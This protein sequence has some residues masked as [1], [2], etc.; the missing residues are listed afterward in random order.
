M[1]VEEAG[2]VDNF[3]RE[4]CCFIKMIA[5]NEDPETDGD[6]ISAKAEELKSMLS[7]IM[8]ESGFLINGSGAAVLEFFYDSYFIG[9]TNP[10]QKRIL[11]STISSRKAEGQTQTLIQKPSYTVEQADSF[12]IFLMDLITRWPNYIDFIKNRYQE[13]SYSS[14]VSLCCG[15]QLV[16]EKILKF[17][18]VTQIYNTCFGEIGDDFTYNINLSDNFSNITVRP[19]FHGYF[20]MLMI[21]LK[22]DFFTSKDNLQPLGGTSLDLIKTMI[23]ALLINYADKQQQRPENTLKFILSNDFDYLIE[24]TGQKVLL[25]LYKRAHIECVQEVS[26][27][28]IKVT[29]GEPDRVVTV[30][31]KVFSH[32]KLVI[33]SLDANN[34]ANAELVGV[35]NIIKLNKDQFPLLNLDAG[36]SPALEEETEKGIR[37][38]ELMSTSGHT[39]DTSSDFFTY[40]AKE[41][42]D[43][44]T[45][46]TSNQKNILVQNLSDFTMFTITMVPG[47]PVTPRF[48]LMFNGDIQRTKLIEKFLAKFS[49]GIP[50][51]SVSIPE[52]IRLYNLVYSAIEVIISGDMKAYLSSNLPS[53]NAASQQTPSRS[54]QRVKQAKSSTNNNNAEVLYF[55][56][57][58]VGI[59]SLKS[60]GDL[61]PYY[62]TLIEALSNY[63]SLTIHN[64]QECIGYVSSAD[65]SMS[66]TPL[67]YLTINGS[68]YKFPCSVFAGIHIYNSGYIVPLNPKEKNKLKLWNQISNYPVSRSNRIFGIISKFKNDKDIIYSLYYGDTNQLN[69]QLTN[70][71]I[72]LKSYLAEPKNNELLVRYADTSS[73]IDELVGFYLEMA[74]NIKNF[75]MPNSS[76]FASFDTMDLCG[77]LIQLC[78]RYKFFTRINRDELNYYQILL[79]E[80]CTN[81]THSQDDSNLDNFEIKKDDVKLY[82][83]ADGCSQKQTVVEE[84]KQPQLSQSSPLQYLNTQQR[85]NTSSSSSSSAPTQ[86]TSLNRE[87]HVP[88][89]DPYTPPDITFR[90]Q[91]P[92]SLALSSSQLEETTTNGQQDEQP[93]SPRVEKRPLDKLEGPPNESEASESPQNESEN[94]SENESPQKKQRPGSL[95]SRFSS[96]VSNGNYFKNGGNKNTKTYK[97]KYIKNKINKTYGNKKI[98]NNMNKTCGNK[99]LIKK[100]HNTFRK[101]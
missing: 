79:H 61:I 57:I 30:F 60:M 4:L 25:E 64:R 36:N 20:V 34:R 35:E 78:N 22:H 69:D 56:D 47:T 21:E 5:E 52:V 84:E 98:K 53:L 54:S 44:F 6:N 42:G 94:E 74:E 33:A 39:F 82:V 46:N 55:Q 15:N 24:L 72:L 100:T 10:S 68:Q 2:P 23:K 38:V 67:I 91:P 27:G 41:H 12:K 37:S 26:D 45:E 14:F 99:K 85:R 62:I 9:D 49:Q 83:V 81:L 29:Y 71:R 80:V 76:T 13:D 101:K 59:I 48:R 86:S 77:D 40:Q 66:Q 7:H 90:D 58:L 11:L 8:G 32:E 51:E 96:W 65:F 17:D 92:S 75:P 1:N 89:L 3:F 73:S 50:F 97:K 95:L 19:H 16:K 70:I 87:E 63:N 43:Y 18:K 28:S 88:T 93:S 31:P